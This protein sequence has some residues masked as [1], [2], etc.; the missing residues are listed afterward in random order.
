MGPEGPE[1]V[2][3]RSC[4]R[5]PSRATVS[6]HNVRAARMW[7]TIGGEGI[8][9]ACPLLSEAWHAA[10]HAQPAPRSKVDDLR[11]ILDDLDK[12]VVV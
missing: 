4:D 10:L 5:R 8:V 7:P 11:V 1:K 3:C 9:R 2:L 12:V 6:S